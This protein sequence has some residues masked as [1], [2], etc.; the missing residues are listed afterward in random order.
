MSEILDRLLAIDKRDAAYYADDHQLKL[1][2]GAEVELAE[3]RGE[4]AFRRKQYLITSS[5]LERA[6]QTIR[7]LGNGWLTGDGQTIALNEAANI[8]EALEKAKG[9]IA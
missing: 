3:L 7:N 4:L 9:P 5:A 8:R 2:A 6:E 1:I